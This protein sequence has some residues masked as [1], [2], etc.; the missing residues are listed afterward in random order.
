M[1]GKE[2]I[3]RILKRLPVDRVGVYEQFWN[4]AIKK[5]VSEK[6]IASAGELPDRFGFDIAHGGGINLTADID[7]VPEIIAEDESTVTS[8]DGNG[9][10]FRRFKNREGVMEHIGFAVRCREDWE[11]LIKP[12][13]TPIPARAAFAHYRESKRLAE[14]S[15]RFFAFYCSNVFS[16]MTCVAG[17]EHILHGM[18]DD[19][20]WIDDMCETYAGLLCE[21]QDMLFSKEGWPDC[22]WYTEDLGFKGRPFMSPAMFERHIKPGYKKS[23]GQCHEN[24]TPVVLH[25]CGFL[26]PFLPH[27]VDIG[28]DALQAIEVKSG[29]D[30]LRIHEKYGDRLVLIGGMDAREIESNDPSRIKAEI[31]AKMPVLMAK[32]GYILHSDHSISNNVEYESLEYFIDYGKTAGTYRTII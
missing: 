5:W 32:G 7:F 26:E 31:D 28:L 10:T 22:L 6:K 8:L 30:V 27:L 14:E 17:H 1:N 21:M 29:M 18:A 16:M 9:A 4:D 15:G 13:L 20:E 11:R 3:S 24:N 25:S 12:K 2:R 19:P 23:F